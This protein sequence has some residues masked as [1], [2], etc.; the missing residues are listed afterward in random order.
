MSRSLS[1]GDHEIRRQQPG[2]HPGNLEVQPVPDVLDPMFG[3]PTAAFILY[4]MLSLPFRR[5]PAVPMCLNSSYNSRVH[6]NCWKLIPINN[7]IANS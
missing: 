5:P 1:T 2:K 7:S 4:S 6:L 3:N